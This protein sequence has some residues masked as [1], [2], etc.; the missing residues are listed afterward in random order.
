MYYMDM[1]LPHILK[2][3]NNFPAFGQPSLRVTFE[4]AF[5]DCSVFLTNT[6]SKGNWRKF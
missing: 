5:G 6:G 2:I 3:V 1:S 4:G